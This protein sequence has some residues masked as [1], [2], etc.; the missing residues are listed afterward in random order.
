[1][2]KIKRIFAIAGVILLLGIYILT[3]FTA[4]FTNYETRGLFMACLFSTFAIPIILYAMM[5]VT[6]LL[7]AEGGKLQKEMEPFEDPDEESSNEEDLDEEDPDEES[8]D[9]ETESSEKME[10]EANEVENSYE[11]LEHSKPLP[12]EEAV[13]ELNEITEDE[14]AYEHPTLEDGSDPEGEDELDTEPLP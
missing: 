12:S 14:E 13:E 5:L 6:R 7:K 1:M 10:D 8:S 11:P 3:F 9:K 4:C 2:K